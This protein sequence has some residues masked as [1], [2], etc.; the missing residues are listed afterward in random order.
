MRAWFDPV[1]HE[2][3][4]EADGDEYAE[5]AAAA[6]AGEATLPAV[7]LAM[8][9]NATVL[10]LPNVAVRPSPDPAAPLSL[11]VEGPG[12]VVNGGAEHL[13]LLARDFEQLCRAEPGTT[14]LAEWF[15]GHAYLAAG[16][17]PVVFARVGDTPAPG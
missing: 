17:V 6:R 11:R 2:A 5:L 16:S 13:D 1:T 10:P 15:P 8:V 7:R 9:E 3:R 14:L 4:L 12:L